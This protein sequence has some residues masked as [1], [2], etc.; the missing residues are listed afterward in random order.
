MEFFFSLYNHAHNNIRLLK[1]MT[2][3]LSVYC[4]LATIL[5]VTTIVVSK[6]LDSVAVEPSIAQ[7]ISPELEC[8][9]CESISKSLENKE[10]LDKQGSKCKN[11]DNCIT[12]FDDQNQAKPSPKLDA[13]NEDHHHKKK[14]ANRIQPKL[15]TAGITAD[16][17]NTEF[18]L[19]AFFVCVIVVYISIIELRKRKPQ[20]MKKNHSSLNAQSGNVIRMADFNP[21]APRQNQTNN[22]KSDIN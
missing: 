20:L 2:K 18:L 13:K 15:A 5:T 3:S 1:M 12:T 8:I 10:S 17:T 6:P 22:G 7:E 11:D 19:Y 16:I 4:L 21:T 9:E 14:Q